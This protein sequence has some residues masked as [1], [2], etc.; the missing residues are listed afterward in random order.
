MV[1]IAVYVRHRQNKGDIHC[2]G[3]MPHPG[4][5]QFIDICVMGGCL[6]WG[7]LSA[8]FSILGEDALYGVYSFAMLF[9]G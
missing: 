6:G 8:A 3:Y 1:L 4:F 9:V 7:G 2:P 5:L